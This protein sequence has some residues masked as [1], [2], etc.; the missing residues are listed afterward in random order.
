MT[1]QAEPQNG[2]GGPGFALTAGFQ[3]AGG[4]SSHGSGPGGGPHYPQPPVAGPVLSG[5]LVAGSPQAALPL[6]APQA[7][8]AVVPV[9]LAAGDGAAPAATTPAPVA[10]ADG[11]A[12]AVVISPTSPG[13][14]PGPATGL[15]NPVPAAPQVGL[16]PRT[17]A[18][19]SSTGG[20]GPSAPVSHVA[21]D[22]AGLP[23]QPAFP[24]RT[25]VVADEAGHPAVV[26][27]VFT[28][29][30]PGPA[31]APELAQAG[32]P[33]GSAADVF[34]GDCPWADAGLPGVYPDLRLA[35]STPWPAYTTV[36]LG[37]S[38]AAYP[39]EL[40]GLVVSPSAAGGEADGAPAA[41]VGGAGEAQRV[42]RREKT[43]EPAA[44]AWAFFAGL[45]AFTSVDRITA[46]SYARWAGRSERRPPAD[47]E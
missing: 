31:G 30:A 12:P 47:K 3:D 35:E 32:S 6:A 42:A 17:G 29:F 23:A 14:A 37:E 24:A 43:E 10:A 4:G 1:S 8:L 44:R 21:T 36:A 45:A 5:I 26:G 46:R 22:I 41:D 34:A 40:A 7:T 25:L 2:P 20:F 39:R 15:I 18:V 11:P 19:E 9:L 13:P 28:V 16:A 33:G 38:A 27:V